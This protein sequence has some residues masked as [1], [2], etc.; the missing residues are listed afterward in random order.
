MYRAII[1][2]LI[3]CGSPSPWTPPKGTIQSTPTQEAGA[4]EVLPGTVIIGLSN[5]PFN[6]V[7]GRIIEVDRAGEIVW[8]YT[9]PADLNTP[10]TLLYDVEPLDDGT[11]LFSLNGSGFYRINRAGEIIWQLQDVRASHDVDL[12]ASGNILATHTY[13]PYGKPM[14]VEYTPEGEIVWSW[15]G[16]DVFNTER[17]VNFLDESDSWGHS[18]SV[19]LQD[20]GN[21]RVSVRSFNTIV[22]LNR[23]GEV[24][25]SMGFDSREDLKS[26]RVEGGIKGARPH[27]PATTHQRS[28]YLVAL[29]NP[30]R[31]AEI[32]RSTG[33]IKRQWRAPKNDSSYHTIRDTNPLPG[34][35]WL[36]TTAEHILEVDRTGTT[37]WEYD[38][39]ETAGFEHPEDFSSFFK[40]TFIGADGTIYGN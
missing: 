28:R 25:D 15:D 33:K 4:T 29:R 24:V 5:A 16:T 27:D 34:G 20:N 13:A 26:V 6:G 31:V 2:L 21:I 11:I 36:I 22:E 3:G 35:N 1:A 8:E 32:E 7:L 40:A 10:D 38:A 39:V 14:V 19:R 23:A 37:V 30:H 17:Q 9:L 18:N 12:L